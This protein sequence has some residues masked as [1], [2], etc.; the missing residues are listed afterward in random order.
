MGA[1]D[2]LAHPPLL[3]LLS[4]CSVLTNSTPQAP[5]ANTAHSLY[6]QAAIQVLDR[7]FTQPGLSYLLV[8]AHSGVVLTSRWKNYD[9]P[10]PLG[11]LVKPFTALAYAQSHDFSYPTYECRGFSTGCWQSR[12]HGKLDIV[13]AISISCN[14]YFRLLAEHVSPQDILPIVN[15]F[16]LEPPDP[17]FETP[18]LL[19]IGAQW[20]ISPL[21]MARAYLELV[22]R[23]NQPGVANLLAGMSQSAKQGT[24][25][26]V[27]R[28]LGNTDALVKTGT[29]PCSHDPMAPADGFV[30]V[31]VPS[32][33]P[34][35]L[36][37]LRI[38]GVAGAKAAETA[39]RI[40]S[41]MQE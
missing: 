24:G 8:D 23:R 38:H 41:R 36:L 18:A 5:P 10:I 32:Q 39:G 20:R 12:P 35:I 11:S 40:L 2:R 28:A 7:E 15:E 14:S 34:E 26:A 16:S 9:K 17:D 29:A 21:H 6:S 13:S 25:A 37:M 30:I 3:L 27:G 1:L 4:T 22:R 31:M 33:Q 19:G